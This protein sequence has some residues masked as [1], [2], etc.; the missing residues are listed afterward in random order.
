[1]AAKSLS[2]GRSRRP[3]D[4]LTTSQFGDACEYLVLAEL[5]LAE[6][7]AHKMP[8]GWPGYDLSVSLGTDRDARVSVKA[9]RVGLGRTATAWSFEPES[10]KADWVALVAI[11]MDDH[12]RRVYMVPHE[13]AMKNSRHH[14]TTGN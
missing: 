5:L 11:N 13:W 2:E 12:S 9:R 6:Q 8:D 1:M 10:T 3:A 7:I 4:K 14:K